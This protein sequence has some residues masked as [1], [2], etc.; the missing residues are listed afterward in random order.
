[1]S[2]NTQLSLP[3][4]VRTALS[5][6]DVEAEF[7]ALAASSAEI[8]TITNQAGYDQCHAARMRL[9]K[10]RTTTARRG[11]DVREDAQAFAKAVIAEE[12]RLI[13]IIEPE[14]ARLQALQKAED[15]KREAKIR[16]ERE[17]A[18]GI[19]AHIAGYAEKALAMAGKP[20]AEIAE[21]LESMRKI[22]VG[23]WAG[24]YKDDAKVARDKAI[25]TLEQLHAGALTQEKERAE[26][27]AKLKAEAEE[28][29]RLR[30]EQVKR[31]AEAKERAEAEAKAQAEA[32]A[33][34]EADE[35]AARERREADDRA[36]QAERD[37]QDAIARSAREAEQKRLDE[38]A[39]AQRAAAAAEEARLKKERDEIEARE[40]EAR[41]LETELAD[42]QTVLQVFKDRFGKRRE[43]SGVVK[44]I[45]A[46]FVAK[47]QKV[48]A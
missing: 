38:I 34:I 18:E 47:Q 1:M 7:R 6:P 12:K 48:A 21:A 22:F 5:S 31:D 26:Q 17:R 39:A 33:K 40:R 46:Y 13:G 9:V 20:A 23:E 10:A 32:R 4:R 43:F 44:A 37:R 19:L 15:D 24:E 41:R 25:A 45:D 8:V 30:A 27:E 28:L 36:A 14:E 35:K 11:K 42:G 2:G 16:A 3:E 29:A